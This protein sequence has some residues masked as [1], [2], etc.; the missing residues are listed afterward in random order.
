MEDSDDTINVVVRVRPTISREQKEGCKEFWKVEDNTICLINDGSSTMHDNFYIFDYIFDKQK[1]N[2]DVYNKVR[3]IVQSAIDGINGTVFAYGQTSSGKTHSIMGDQK[4]KGI[5]PLAIDDIF[6]VI[7]NDNKRKYLLRSSY[8]E[9]YND[10]IN[11][12]LN[13]SQTDLKIREDISGNL[14]IANCVEEITRSSDELMDV[15]MKG[16]RNRQIFGT[17]MNERSSRSHVIFKIVIESSPSDDVCGDEEIPVQVSQLYFVDLAGS[18]RVAQTKATGARLKE[19]GQI[20]KSLSILSR[21]IRQLAENVSHVNFRDSKL[22]RLLSNALGG[23]CKTLIIAAVTPVSIENTQSTLM[24]AQA[25]KTIKTKP[26]VNQVLTNEALIKQQKN[27]EKKLINQL[28]LERTKNITLQ[29]NQSMKDKM[30]KSLEDQIKNIQLSYVRREPIRTSSRRHTMGFERPSSSMYS[31]IPLLRISEETKPSP[32]FLTA[33]PAPSDHSEEALDTITIPDEM[34]VSEVESTCSTPKRVLRQR[35]VDLDESHT[36]LKKF[37]QYE[38]D[39][40]TMELENLNKELETERTKRKDIEESFM[41]MRDLVDKLEIKNSEMEISMESLKS[42]FKIRESELLSVMSKKKSDIAQPMDISTIDTDKIDNKMQCE[43]AKTSKE[44]QIREDKL[45]LEA[46]LVMAIE[47]NKLLLEE[48]SE[49]KF[50]ETLLKN[51]I[52]G[53]SQ[54]EN[55]STDD[56]TNIR[57]CDLRKSI[58]DS[59]ICIYD[60]PI[61]VRSSS[62]PNIN[63]QSVGLT[64]SNEEIFEDLRKGFSSLQSLLTAN[65]SHLTKSTRE[66]VNIEQNDYVNNL[67]IRNNDL[68]MQIIKLQQENEK[69]LN[70]HSAQLTTMNDNH[71][72]QVMTYENTVKELSGYNKTMA[73]EYNSQLTQAN[74]QASIELSDGEHKLAK[75]NITISQLQ[76]E[77]LTV[78]DQLNLNEKSKTSEIGKIQSTYSEQLSA[79]QQDIAN[80]KQEENECT[81]EIDL[82]KE[83][84]KKYETEIDNLKLNITK[85]NNY[86]LERYNNY[87]RVINEMQITS[88]TVLEEKECETKMVSEKSMERIKELE[89]NISSLQVE[90][91]TNNKESIE[92]SMEV[93]RLQLLVES[94][95]SSLD[96]ANRSYEALQLQLQQEKSSLNTQVET[97]NK[98]RN[99]AIKQSKSMQEMYQ[100]TMDNLNAASE[101]S[102]SIQ[103][104]SNKDMNL[105][106]SELDQAIEEKKQLAL[107]LTNVRQQHEQ[108]NAATNEQLQ[109]LK[110][111]LNAN[112]EEMKELR[113]LLAEKDAHLKNINDDLAQQYKQKV[114]KLEDDIKRQDDTVRVRDTQIIELT[115]S[116]KNASDEVLLLKEKLSQSIKCNEDLLNEGS[117]QIQHLEEELNLKHNELKRTERLFEELKLN[118][119]VEVKDL[120]D[121]IKQHEPAVKRENDDNDTNNEDSTIPSDMESDTKPLKHMLCE[122]AIEIKRLEE[123]LNAV[124]NN[125]VAAEKANEELE[126]NYKSLYDTHEAEMTIKNQELATVNDTIVQ[127][128]RRLAD[129]RTELKDARINI[130]DLKEKYNLEISQ[131]KAN[132]KKKESEL[133]LDKDTRIIRNHKE[134]IQ[135]YENKLRSVNAI[136]DR[137]LEE[138]SDQVKQLEMEV[139]SVQE[140][141]TAA[142]NNHADEIERVRAMHSEEMRA[143]MQ[144]NDHKDSVKINELKDSYEKTMQLQNIEIAALQKKLKEELRNNEANLKVHTIS[145]SN[146]ANALNVAEEKIKKTTKEIENL[147]ETHTKEVKNI[148]DNHNRVIENYRQNN[149]LLKSYAKKNND[150]ESEITNLKIQILT[151]RKNCDTMTESY[152]TNVTKINQDHRKEIKSLAN[153]STRK[154]E[155]CKEIAVILE[156]EKCETTKLKEELNKALLTI[157][158]LTNTTDEQKKN[159]EDID[160]KLH[161]LN[162]TIINIRAINE[163]HNRT[164]KELEKDV[165]VK[166][167]EIRE[168]KKRNSNLEEKVKEME[169]E[170]ANEEEEESQETEEVDNVPEVAVQDGAI[171]SLDTL[172][173]NGC[174]SCEQTINELKSTVYK[175]TLHNSKLIDNCYRLRSKNQSLQCKINDFRK[176]L[177]KTKNHMDTLKKTLESEKD[178]TRK[179]TENLTVSN[180]DVQVLKAKLA[181]EYANVEKLNKKIV[182]LQTAQKIYRT[183]L[184]EQTVE[185]RF[186]EANTSKSFQEG[187][188]ERRQSLHDQRRDI[189]ACEKCQKRRAEIAEYQKSNDNLMKLNQMLND[190]HKILQ[191]KLRSDEDSDALELQDQ[192]NCTEILLRNL[193]RCMTKG[194]DACEHCTSLLNFTNKKV[195]ALSKIS[196]TNSFW[197]TKVETDSQTINEVLKLVDR[198]LPILGNLESESLKTLNNVKCKLEAAKKMLANKRCYIETFLEEL[199]KDVNVLQPILS[200]PPDKRCLFFESNKNVIDFFMLVIERLT[201]SLKYLDEICLEEKE[202]TRDR[203]MELDQNVSYVHDKIVRNMPCSV[204]ILNYNQLALK[205]A[206]LKALIRMRLDNNEQ[207]QDIADYL[208]MDDVRQQTAAQSTSLS[209]FIPSDTSFHTVIPPASTSTSPPNLLLRARRKIRNV[210]S[211]FVPTTTSVHT[212]IPPA[213]TSTS[214]PNLL[215]RARKLRDMQKKD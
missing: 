136:N 181:V 70:E 202:K 28:E 13:K 50:R 12:L 4:E 91:E 164:I 109:S 29:V 85:Q 55:M 99:E 102:K 160:C 126:K 134:Q 104:E 113:V 26:R 51:K 76:K 2:A 129:S 211:T 125:L 165:A 151:A 157:T 8:I 62:S 194:Y 60:E 208:P 87:E 120:E 90:L 168:I 23:N 133:K 53:S 141:I 88:K 131:L 185:S 46:K 37:N 183:H 159:K 205:Y 3:P 21:V 27:K 65:S 195:L 177:Q 130:E 40:N 9:I 48:N 58:S 180:S 123:Q 114:G 19:G 186:E 93:K 95:Q 98:E 110:S 35:L 92:I 197:Y 132:H 15:V 184:K 61:M 204:N 166:N 182:E 10:K 34:D 63:D 142:Y 206:S 172:E 175:T 198:F 209:S 44:F 7:Q 81:D 43:E 101:Y 213:S 14:S 174:S 215:L 190:Q 107:E 191:S 73:D 154:E 106:R 169:L 18:E 150:L 38:H 45:C 158:K 170:K 111:T 97:A 103:H 72:A 54:N 121:K 89:A 32:S 47:Q 163:K 31:K 203:I 179:M 68:E 212:F 152:L 59:K 122:C 144:A 16:N 6:H 117:M 199:K 189:D 22:T 118:H 96:A 201:T 83:A 210:P 82:I 11:D 25:A 33:E 77:L 39:F 143:L 56:L 173:A 167:Q 1:K 20:N 162:T 49:I 112:N 57:K 75:A 116:L 124:R 200:S 94:G 147:K 100:T 79:I 176:A 80:K 17:A 187:V 171:A 5:I 52:L 193:N 192:F 115:A 66:E 42:R 155:E 214:P 207:L 108:I 71:S 140:K 64:N 127:Y 119:I 135:A 137:L 145:K 69:L 78:Q 84:L 153:L 188:K 196:E 148:N 105:M 178:N 41:S 36:E 146:L 161:I 74:T 86:S 67:Q 138:S 30:I 128:Q 156:K 139:Q 24:F 149:D